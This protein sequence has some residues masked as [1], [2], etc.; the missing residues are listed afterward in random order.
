MLS[1]KTPCLFI[2]SSRISDA[3]VHYFSTTAT[4][5]MGALTKVAKPQLHLIRGVR[6][7]IL[8]PGKRSWRRTC[9]RC[10]ESSSLDT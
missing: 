2:T 7:P 10:L 4:Q 3:L 9:L 5:H 8:L 6:I 1:A